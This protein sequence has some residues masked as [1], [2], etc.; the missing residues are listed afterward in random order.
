M[1]YYYFFKLIF[2]LTIAKQVSG[3]TDGIYDYSALSFTALSSK[4]KPGQM[5]LYSCRMG[6]HLKDIASPVFILALGT[7]VSRL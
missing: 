7:H 6:D 4:V 5:G 1:P 2:F 3:S